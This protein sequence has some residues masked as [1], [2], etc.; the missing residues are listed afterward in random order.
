MKKKKKLPVLLFKKKKPIEPF[1]TT[2]KVPAGLKLFFP[3][4]LTGFSKLKIANDKKKSV[5]QRKNK[6][7][8][9]KN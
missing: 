3:A 4:H 9:Q 1:Y 6:T 8:Y 2:A 5:V 7:S